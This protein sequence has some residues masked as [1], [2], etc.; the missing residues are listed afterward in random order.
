LFFK[1]PAFV[2][3]TISLTILFVCIFI[4]LKYPPVAIDYG[5]PSPVPALDTTLYLS[6]TPKDHLLDI[7]ARNREGSDL[8][9]LDAFFARHQRTLTRKM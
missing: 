7:G 3:L 1:S 6:M 4:N 9:E 8:E 2:S 5:S